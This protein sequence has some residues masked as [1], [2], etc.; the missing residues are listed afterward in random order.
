[1]AKEDVGHRLAVGRFCK[2]RLSILADCQLVQYGR[3]CLLSV[4]VAPRRRLVVEA[5]GL[6]PR[7]CS[8]RLLAHEAPLPPAVRHRD[9]DGRHAFLL[10][11]ELRL[12][13]RPRGTVLLHRPETLED[14]P[15]ADQGP[16]PSANRHVL[17]RPRQSAA[18]QHDIRQETSQR[19]DDLG[20][21]QFKCLVA[22]RKVLARDKTIPYPFLD[23]LFRQRRQRQQ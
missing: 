20:L 1:M 23:T 18:A 19:L 12:A 9:H 3:K 8:H 16:G 21:A 4:L 11:L 22:G 14:G 17:D 2:L 10:Q 15:C 7:V 6:G 13:R 5:R